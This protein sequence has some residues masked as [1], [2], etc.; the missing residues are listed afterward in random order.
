MKGSLHNHAALLF[1]VHIADNMLQSLTFIENE[2]IQSLSLL[3][4]HLKIRSI[5]WDSIKSC[6]THYLPY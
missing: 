2:F 4:N 6:G 3:T 5:K 1:F